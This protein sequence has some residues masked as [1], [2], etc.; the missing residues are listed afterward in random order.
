[1]KLRNL[2]PSIIEEQGRAQRM[3]CRRLE[4]NSGLLRLRT[5][6]E[7]YIMF[8]WFMMETCLFINITIEVYLFRFPLFN[9][10]G[11]LTDDLWQ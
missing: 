1:M 4:L 10:I 6:A 7:D 5:A 8:C 9:Y 3:R 11:V 2:W